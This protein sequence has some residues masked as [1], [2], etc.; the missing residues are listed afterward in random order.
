MGASHSRAILSKWYIMPAV[1]TLVAYKHP[2]KQGLLLGSLFFSIP[3]G[4]WARTNISLTMYPD[5]NYPE[6][7]EPTGDESV[8]EAIGFLV[9]FGATGGFI[10]SIVMYTIGYR[11]G[12][13]G[14]PK[15][16]VMHPTLPDGNM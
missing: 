5:G 10:W 13:Y 12:I 7:E 1:L 15:P 3:V 8:G 4:V 14:N 2:N 6:Y 16:R 11:K 9:I